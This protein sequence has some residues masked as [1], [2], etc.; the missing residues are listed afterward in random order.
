MGEVHQQR[1]AARQEHAQLPEPLDERLG[2]EGEPRHW[3]S[4]G[5]PVSR[6]SYRLVDDFAP[7]REIGTDHAEEA[8]LL[9]GTE[10]RTAARDRHCGFE[11]GA[12]RVVVEV[13]LPCKRV[14]QFRLARFFLRRSGDGFRIGPEGDASS[15]GSRNRRTRRDTRAAACRGSPPRRFRPG[16]AASFPPRRAPA[17]RFGTRR[18]RQKAELPAGR[19]R[20][21]G[22]GVDGGY[23]SG[24]GRSVCC[25]GTP[26]A[27]PG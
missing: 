2:A 13:D 25:E 9:V 19:R 11:R 26:L 23:R 24:A 5:A 17:P 12:K 10:L 8:S 22:P 18:T 15:R 4:V 14:E 21:A 3:P 6:A 7:A 20:W 1:V 16:A 27:L